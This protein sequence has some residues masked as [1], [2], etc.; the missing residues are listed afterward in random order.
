MKTYIIPEIK[1]AM[2]EQVVSAAEVTA[3]SYVGAMAEQ[4]TTAIAK[5]FYNI[6]YQK[7]ADTTLS[8]Q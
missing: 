8:F 1:I 2:F 6:D 4:G 3:P 5:K 7:I